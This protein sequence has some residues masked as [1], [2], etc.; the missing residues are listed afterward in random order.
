MDYAAT[1]NYLTTTADT[2][3]MMAALLIPVLVTIVV[4]VVQAFFLAK[5]F[6][7]AGSESWFAWVPIANVY[8]LLEIGG[9][10][11][12]YAFLL[13]LGPIGLATLFFFIPAVHRVNLG[14]GKSTGWTILSVLCFP[15]WAVLMGLNSAP[16]RGGDW[17]SGDAATIGFPP[18]AAS[19]SSES[20]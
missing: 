13:F 4:Y 8:R 1:T 7:K 18:V 11:G 16:W 6:A 5:V 20:R 2:G 12:Y 3:G 10:R 19:R 17:R 15:V 14:F 9:Q